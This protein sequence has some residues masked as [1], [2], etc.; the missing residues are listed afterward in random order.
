MTF[1]ISNLVY[2]S[3]LK[4]YFMSMGL[5]S[6]SIPFI[7][8]FVL[9]MQ[10][11]YIQVSSFLNTSWMLFMVY[12]CLVAS[13]FDKYFYNKNQHTRIIRAVC[14]NTGQDITHSI[15]YYYFSDPIKSCAS[16]YRWLAKF[17]YTCTAID[18]IYQHNQLIYASR[19]DLENDIDLN[20]GREIPFGDIKLY[21]LDGKQL[22][23]FCD[24]TP[25]SYDDP[26]HCHHD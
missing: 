17:G 19:V 5:V 16:L 6:A 11:R 26:N 8:C 21:T 25:N 2:F 20:T 23:K 14:C 15:R 12:A 4:Q 9:W 22:Y 24:K 13:A 18:I 3:K 7:I 1:Q 10:D